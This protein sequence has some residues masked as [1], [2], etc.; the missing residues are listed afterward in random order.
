MA[1]VDVTE[2]E[3]AWRWISLC[4]ASLKEIRDLLKIIPINLLI[5]G[6]INVLMS[7]IFEDQRQEICVQKKLRKVFVFENICILSERHFSMESDLR[8]LRD[9][10]N[11]FRSMRRI[12]EMALDEI[13]LKRIEF[14]SS[15]TGSASS[16]KSVELPFTVHSWTAERTFIF[17]LTGP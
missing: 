2:V 12:A 10:L 5:N 9:N 17:R 14:S 11:H 1:R 6:S 8:G 4:T 15:S 7:E 16:S 3:E 13:S